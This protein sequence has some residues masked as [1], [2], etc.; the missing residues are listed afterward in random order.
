MN[1]ITNKI[2]ISVLLIGSFFLLGE[3]PE[4]SQFKEMIN[5]ASNKE[6]VIVFNSGGWGNTPLDQADDFRP[7]IEGIQKTLKDLGYDSVVV[8]YERTKESFFGII[9]G[10]KETFTLF[11]KQSQKL[12]IEI[13]DFIANNPENKVIITGLSNGGA[14]TDKVMEKISEDKRNNVFAIE[15]GTPFWEDVLDSGSVLLLDNQGKDPLSAM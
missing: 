1:R 4:N 10:L 8:P 15:V 11:Q 13:E 9:E 7:I 3:P 14:F 12:A 5:L 2:I 6:V